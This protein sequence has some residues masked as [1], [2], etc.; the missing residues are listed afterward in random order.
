M[1]LVTFS[2][3]FFSLSLIVYATSI[4]L[5]RDQTESSFEKRGL[6]IEFK[7]FL[8]FSGV[9]KDHFIF[10]LQV[11]IIFALS[12]AQRVILPCTFISFLFCFLFFQSRLIIGSWL[13]HDKQFLLKVKQFIALNMVFLG[14]INLEVCIECTQRSYC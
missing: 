2:F 11:W 10:A 1:P 7:L 12:I 4:L 5:M 13:T 3:L 8:G 9:Y 6:E 14:L